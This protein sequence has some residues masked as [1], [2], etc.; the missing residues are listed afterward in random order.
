MSATLLDKHVLDI[1]CSIFDAHS[2]VLFLPEGDGDA[3]TIA[4]WFS[5]GDNI[6]E[7]A[8]IRPGEG[9]VGWIILERTR[10]VI[11]PF[12]Q[13]EGALG[14]YRA[15]EAEGIKAFMG[16][17][18]PT[19]GALIVDS[20]RQYSF[21]DKDSKILQMF[22]ELISMQQ[23]LSA[24]SLSSD[25]SRYFTDLAMIQNLR[26]RYKHWPVFLQ[27]FL[28]IIV[29]ST[30]F[31]YCAFASLEGA[32]QSFLIEGESTPLLLADGQPARMP[33]GAGIAGLVFMNGSEFVTDAR[34]QQPAAIFGKIEDFPNFRSAI[35]MPVEVNKSTCGVLALASSSVIEIDEC[36]RSFVRQA[37]DHLGLFLE[38]LYLK[39]RLKKVLPRVN[40]KRE[41]HPAFDSY[42]AMN[43]RPDN[44]QI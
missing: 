40:V 30:D 43:K 16:V 8:V 37:V 7:R 36:M 13:N 35:C 5:L 9:L 27:N 15:G 34:S 12:D 2:A 11:C 24:H 29:R 32:G 25:I 4:A 19:G 26:F 44:D 18:L 42:T 20:K 17:P 31:D 1:V 14:Y 38:N 3:H 33:L 10:L 6:R 39:N 21:S 22:A 23:T 28:D 41:A